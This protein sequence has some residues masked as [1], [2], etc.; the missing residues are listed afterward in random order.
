MDQGRIEALD[1]PV[2]LKEAYKAGDMNEVFVQ[3]AR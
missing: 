3:I 2:N 1:T